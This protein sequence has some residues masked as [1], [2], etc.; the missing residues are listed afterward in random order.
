MPKTDVEIVQFVFN[1]PDHSADMPAL[2]AFI[3]DTADRRV[4]S[5]VHAHL[6]K[7]SSNW[8]GEQRTAL[9]S[10]DSAGE[11]LLAEHYR[12][13]KQARDEKSQ[14]ER[15]REEDR[16]YA[17]AN[18]RKKRKHDYLVA[19]FQALVAFIL[20]LLADYRFE[21]VRSVVEFFKK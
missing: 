17:A 5:M 21:I 12:Q 16:A 20:G 11:A 10:V 9:Y 3:G 6:L 19:V 2:R 7:C 8:F 4:L 15:Q 14:R 18:D 13:L 1:R